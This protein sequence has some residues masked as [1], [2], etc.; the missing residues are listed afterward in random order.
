TVIKQKRK[1]GSLF[2]D[3][4]LDWGS[5][6]EEAESSQKYTSPK[7]GSQKPKPKN[8]RHSQIDLEFAKKGLP[9]K[10]KNNT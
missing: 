9:A 3:F 1:F 4:K 7:L 2:A 10:Y 8:H 6:N 5:N